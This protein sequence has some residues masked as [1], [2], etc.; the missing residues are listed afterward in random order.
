MKRHNIE[1]I[2]GW[3][4]ALRRR[5]TESMAAA[6]D[7]RVVWQGVRPDLVCHG[8]DEVIAAF[9][10]AY[11]ANQEID[12]LELLGGDRHIVLG[13]RAPELAVADVD[14]GGEI[15]NVF[16]IDGDKITRIEDY[17]QREQALRA[18]GTAPSQEDVPAA[19]DSETR[20]VRRASAADAEAIGGLLHDFNA[21]FDDI[22]PGPQA[23]AKRVVELL[24]GGD[25]IVLLAGSG[26]DGL[27]VLRLREAIWMQA[28][29]CYLA[30]LYVVP[31]RRGQGIGRALMEASMDIA[32]EHGAAYMDLGT[33]EDDVAA[34]AL[35]ESLGFSNREGR[36]DGPINYYYEREL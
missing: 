12:S 21:E 2:W 31:E 22:T 17:L 30:E 7:P 33:S 15:Y 32:R 6:L 36:P 20:G 27:A 4:D 10:T 34:R 35:Y 19:R 16:T 26:P 5:D 1:F 18:A 9:V 11:D 24:A 25:T 28:L 29:E 14:T 3:F 23:L 8:P 13:A